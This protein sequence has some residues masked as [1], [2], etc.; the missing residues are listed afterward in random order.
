MTDKPDIKTFWS[1]TAVPQVAAG[2][3]RSELREQLL[4]SMREPRRQKTGSVK[5]AVAAC[6]C[7]FLL[8]ASGWGAQQLYVRYFLLEHGIE[9]ARIMPDG[10]VEQI[11]TSTVLMTDDLTMTSEVANQKWQEMRTAM[12]TG[13][14]VL[15]DVRECGPGEIYYIYSVPAGDGSQVRFGTPR[16][17]P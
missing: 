15:V 4:R 12:A 1:N 14:Y 16:P 9:A 5:W 13:N 10:S 2:H 11:G 17:L 8:A 3:H 7:V 6:C